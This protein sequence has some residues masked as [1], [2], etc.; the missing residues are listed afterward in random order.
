MEE[1]TSTPAE[2]TNGSQQQVDWEA[3]FKGQVKA[4]EKL[5]LEN[6]DLTAQLGS[7]SSEYEQ[8]SAQLGLKDTEK[9]A[10]IDQRDKQLEEVITTK[11]KLESELDDLRA[12]KLKIEVANELNSP[13]LLKI[14]DKVPNMT[15][16]EAL[17]NV[18]KSF[19]DFAKDAADKRERQLLSG[20]TLADNSTNDT[21]PA[22]PDSDAAW[23]KYLESSP[24]GSPERGKA[25]DQYWDWLSVKNK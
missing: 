18:L 8:L 23:E 16:K 2:Q 1:D 6:R 7:K 5:T 3:R 13:E 15:D 22:L 20:I 11:T 12:M 4:I 17:T 10:A 21:T 9:K 14:L 24:L 19:S 25:M